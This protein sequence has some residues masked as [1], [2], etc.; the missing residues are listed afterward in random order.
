MSDVVGKAKNVSETLSS[1]F[2][3]FLDSKPKAPQ[4][5][6]NGAMFIYQTSRPFNGG[7][8]VY[9]GINSVSFTASAFILFR[10][11]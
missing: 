11:A 5:I 2:D 4:P 8:H 9:K 1:I 7:D 6:S 10:N 3:C